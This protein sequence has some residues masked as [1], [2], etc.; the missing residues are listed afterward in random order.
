MSQ[1]SLVI[2]PYCDVVHR[3]VEVARR[4]AACCRRCGSPLYRGAGL[5]VDTTL[6][7]ALTG[8]ILLVLANVYP[9]MSI[10]LGG[11][12][13]A[14]TLV[15]TVATLQRNGLPGVGVLVA[16]TAMLAPMLQLLALAYVSLALRVHHR[17][18]AFLAMMHALHHL[19]TWSM[20]EVLLLGVLVAV[21]KL[22]GLASIT[23]GI[24]MWML[25]L[26]TVTLTVLCADD[27][28]LLW[29]A[30]DALVPRDARGWVSA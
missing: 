5:S 26:L 15:E 16:I 7:L 28:R 20:V 25:G 29:A 12:S 8:L 1:P 3:H 4:T 17:P 30:A 22:S 19:G 24:G 10:S 14:V 21:V 23:P 2:C 27:R 6:C 9:L 13:N 18:R 11:R